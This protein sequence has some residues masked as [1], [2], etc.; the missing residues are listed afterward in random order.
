MKKIILTGLILASVASAQADF[1]ITVS[2]TLEGQP[3]KVEAISVND[4]L[5]KSRKDRIAQEFTAVAAPAFQISTPGEGAQRY[6]IT[7]GDKKLSSFFAMPTD[8][9]YIS[10]GADGDMMVTGT[11]MLDQMA[12]L[13]QQLNEPYKAYRKAAADNDEA[14]ADAAA[15]A[16]TKLLVD[17]VKANPDLCGA[18]WAVMQMEDEEM[19]QYAPSLQGEAVTCMLYPLLLKNIESAKARQE[20]E[21]HQQA[22]EDSHAKAPDFALPDLNGKTV[23]LSQ[24]KGKWVV[25]DF[26]GSWCIWCIKGFPGLKD[27][28]AKYKGKM[29][30]IGVDCNDPEANWRAAVKKYELPWI[31]LYNAQS[32]GGVMEAYGVQAFPTKVLVNPKGK[33]EKIY[34]G[35]DPAFYTDLE[36]LIK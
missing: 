10:I 6:V 25:I 22:L 12:S 7:I 29:E 18:T 30:V 2:P 14:A 17:Y 24:F 20:A 33:I 3:V 31:N 35:E 27:A 32:K 34:I 19:M 13:Q 26:W 4:L 16:Y 5:T 21:K 8:K 15:K 1:R 36:R 28:Y 9:V 23:K 11:P